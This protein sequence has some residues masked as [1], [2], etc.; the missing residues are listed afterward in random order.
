MMMMT[1][2]SNPRMRGEGSSGVER[3]KIEKRAR[4]MKKT[5]KLSH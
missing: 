4:L 3:E 2:K 5:C 1:G